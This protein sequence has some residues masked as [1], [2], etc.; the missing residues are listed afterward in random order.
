MNKD[1]SIN[2]GIASYGNTWQTMF[3]KDLSAVV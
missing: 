2:A 3:S 1:L